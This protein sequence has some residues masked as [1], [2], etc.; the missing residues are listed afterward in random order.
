MSYTETELQARYRS[1]DSG[2]HDAALDE[3][4][5]IIAHAEAGGYHRLAFRA[6]RDLADRHC[7][8]GQWEKGF[9]LFA[10]CLAEFDSRPEDFGPHEEWSLRSWY[11]RTVTTMAEYPEISVEQITGLHADMR[12]RFA[13]HGHSLAG[14]HTAERWLAFVRGDWA[15][16]ENA[17]R[18]WHLAGG[19]RP[20]YMWDYENEIE[21]LVHRGDPASIDRALALAEPVLDGRVTFTETTAPIEAQML[22]HWA[23]R[24]SPERLAEV[25][26]RMDRGFDGGGPWR[27]EYPSMVI[28]FLALTGN[29]EEAFQRYRR[30]MCHFTMLSRPYGRMEFATSSAVALGRLVVLGRGQEPVPC[31]GCDGEHP[32]R[33]L[34]QRHAELRAEA[35]ALAARFD[36]RNGTTWHTTRA[37]RRLAASPLL[38]FLPLQ[39][40][41]RPKAHRIRPI[42][43]PPDVAVH[44]A[45]W[46]LDRGFTVEADQYLALIGEPADPAVA[47]GVLE[48][49]ARRAGDDTTVPLLRAAAAAHAAAGELV[50]GDLCLV[51]AARVLRG[52]KRYA[53][54]VEELARPLERLR[55]EADPESVGHAEVLQADL[56]FILER[57]G[58]GFALIAEVVERAETI[59]DPRL[60]G[61]ARNQAGWMRECRGDQADLI[62]A[63][64]I[65]ATCALAA[66][67]ADFRA[68][69]ALNRLSNYFGKTS[70][71]AAL[72][73]SVT[74]CESALPPHTGRLVIAGLRRLRGQTLQRLDRNE[75]ALVELSFAAHEHAALDIHGTSNRADWVKLAELCA[76][77]GRWEE[78]NRHSEYACAWADRARK[79]GAIDDA[80]TM[81]TGR[82]VLADSLRELGRLDAAVS[83]YHTLVGEALAADRR[84]YARYA[85]DK[86]GDLLLRLNRPA[87][88]ATDFRAAGDL[89][90]EV[91]K[92]PRE[93]RSIRMKEVIAHV[94]AGTVDAAETALAQAREIVA[95]DTDDAARLDLATAHVL[96][97][98]GKAVEAMTHTERAQE[99]LHVTGYH[100]EAGMAALFLA[101]QHLAT[102]RPDLAATVLRSAIARCPQ[103]R[104]VVTE[105]STL[106]ASLAAP[107]R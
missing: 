12:R 46:L 106:L 15:A 29:E 48:L 38:E 61:E 34:A 96:F 45:R 35:L 14:L 64:Y 55:A 87:A 72:V 33:T 6:R 56:E 85:H 50:R 25:F 51:A 43:C 104:P 3:L 41:A 67:G 23:R 27:Y 63:D 59:A 42:G 70:D 16:E 13:A 75:E 28:E 73:D 17:Y 68:R 91:G 5:E 32:T 69:Q 53:D 94:R 99:A 39:P 62:A 84:D 8:S 86:A 24:L 31:L 66:A 98:R 36:T 1:L 83:E 21:R 97:A 80:V 101:Q 92:K 19:P 2:W 100:P 107:V 76:T 82:Y 9:P 65:A 7:V 40:G 30:R 95:T 49:K 26:Q 57:E 47:A 90:A 81:V 89:A 22:P 52:E 105:M 77:L 20:N 44:A 37:T 93:Q 102:A 74:R 78:A 71:W 58:E 60:I 79:R 103:P 88:A 18:Q 10:R 54:A 11:V 4:A